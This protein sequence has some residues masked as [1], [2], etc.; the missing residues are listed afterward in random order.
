MA[1]SSPSVDSCTSGVCDVTLP[2]CVSSNLRDFFSQGNLGGVNPS[3]P[4]SKPLNELIYLLTDHGITT[5]SI[6]M[7]LF[8][9]Y[10]R[11]N[12][13]SDRASCNRVDPTDPNSP[14]RPTEQRDDHHF[15][16]DTLMQRFFQPTFDRLAELGKPINPQNF[17]LADCL[18][19][20][21][22]NQRTRSGQITLDGHLYASH[23]DANPE[24]S[25]EEYAASMDPDVRRTLQ[26]D[27][28]LIRGLARN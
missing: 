17:T 26:A 5:V 22:L 3:N 23:L 13:L 12:K 19:I 9:I 16:I 28:T 10:V 27:W 15:G 7:T 25:D 21:I 14:L 20:I 11:V 1:D 2:I 6:L 24:M 4:H 8:G 18:N